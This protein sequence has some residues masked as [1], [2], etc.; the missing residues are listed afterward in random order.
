M[1]FLIKTSWTFFKGSTDFK[2]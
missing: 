2:L 1:L